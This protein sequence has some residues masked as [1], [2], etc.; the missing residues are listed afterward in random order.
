[1]ATAILKE[2]GLSS[3]LGRSQ[4]RLDLKVAWSRATLRAYRCE[5]EMQGRGHSLQNGYHWLQQTELVASN[6][7]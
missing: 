5:I 4:Y 7:L 3:N 6:R 1:M 2:V